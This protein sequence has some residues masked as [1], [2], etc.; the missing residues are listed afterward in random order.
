[1]NCSLIVSE[2]RARFEAQIVVLCRNRATQLCAKIGGNL[3]ND[4][5]IPRERQSQH[6]DP[7][8]A[9]LF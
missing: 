1:M 9:G 2:L 5:G 4:G 3:R 7:G 6:V 8:G